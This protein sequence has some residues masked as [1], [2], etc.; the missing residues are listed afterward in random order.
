[1]SFSLARSPFLPFCRPVS[2][3]ST[4]NLS[5]W[6]YLLNIVCL[7]VIA[8]CQFHS[9]IDCLY[10]SSLHSQTYLQNLQL[11]VAACKQL[12]DALGVLLML[13]LAESIA[14]APFGI[15][16]EVVGGETVREAE[17]VAVLRRVSTK[18]QNARAFADVHTKDLAACVDG[19]L[20]MY[21]GTREM[22]E[23]MAEFSDDDMPPSRVS[24]VHSVR[25]HPTAAG[26]GIS[27]PKSPLFRPP[28]NIAMFAYPAGYAPHFS[29]AASLF[30]RS[31]CRRLT[32]PRSSA[33]SPR[34]LFSV[35]RSAAEPQ[36]KPKSVAVL[37]SSRLSPHVGG[38]TDHSS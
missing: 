28:P 24:W 27:P 22:L 34:R 6:K 36:Q 29:A 5:N 37:G 10:L 12:L 19:G 15:L 26:G 31:Q 32:T 4:T 20:Y 38:G 25:R 14:G 11:L 7:C 18:H 21:G 9:P 30:A 8:Y 1:V 2:C 13:V 23:Q 33:T 35:T 16:A 17:Q 3:P